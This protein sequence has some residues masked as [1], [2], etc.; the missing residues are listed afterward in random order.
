MPKSNL[1]ACSDGFS[2]PEHST[3]DEIVPL[4]ETSATLELLF[5]FIYPRPLPE[6]G[7]VG[8]E[9]LV[10]LAEA[11]EKYRV[12]AA[13][14]LCT[15]HLL[16]HLQD[17]LEDI[18]LHGLKHSVRKLVDRAAL[19]LVDQPVE[20]VILK[21]PQSCMVPWVRYHAHCARVVKFAISIAPTPES[22]PRVV[23][24]NKDVVDSED[25]GSFS[26]TVLPNGSSVSDEAKHLTFMSSD[27]VAFCL[28]EA[29]VKAYTKSL[30][31]DQYEQ[32]VSL[33]ESSDT[34]KVFFSFLVKAPH[35][36]LEATDFRKLG[37][38]SLAANLYGAYSVL[39]V[40]NIRMAQA[41]PNDLIKRT[42]VVMDYA[43]KSQNHEL[44]EK[45][46]PLL[47]GKPHVEMVKLFQGSNMVIPWV[48]SGGLMFTSHQLT[49]TVNIQ[50]NYLD[51]WDRV[52]Q[53]ASAFSKRR[54]ISTYGFG[55]N[56]RRECQGCD[57]LT[58]DLA[59]IRVMQ[60][61]GEGVKSI[62]DPDATFEVFESEACCSKSR[63]DFASWKQVVQDAIREI[64][65]F[66]TF[67]TAHV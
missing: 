32:P 27:G 13:M 53:V 65:S 29:A 15:I 52:V 47:V 48:G 33:S 51:K 19:L 10:L 8:F 66:N 3:F 17:H 12:Y 43:L 34:L 35:P 36:D 38:L 20:D 26:R 7:K 28:S 31:P 23:C 5:Q 42:S 60:I 30:L 25:Y 49:K 55:R 62:R 22:M 45:S 4:T 11:A 59:T 64:P 46:A 54:K 1:I 67:V 24:N 44:M 57:F 14:N 58:G 16:E 6:L 63:A 18:L 2:P 61:L 37:P 41:L 21:L 40:C 56:K 50:F 39:S 9:A